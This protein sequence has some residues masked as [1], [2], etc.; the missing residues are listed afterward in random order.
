MANPPLL[1]I[2]LLRR[3]RAAP[4]RARLGQPFWLETR[5]LEAVPIAAEQ[6]RPRLCRA[7][8]CDV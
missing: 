7:P 3:L 4:V 5:Y 1:M 8:S 6:P 2:R